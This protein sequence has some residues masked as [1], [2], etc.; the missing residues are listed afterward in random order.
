LSSW[1]V[2]GGPSRKLEERAVERVRVGQL[3]QRPERARQLLGARLVEHAVDVVV[4]VVDEQEAAAIDPRAQV[5]PLRLRERTGRCPVMYPNGWRSSVSDPSGTT[6]PLG[7][8]A[9]RGVAR[10]RVDQVRRHERAP[11]PQSP[12]SY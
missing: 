4:V 10:Q 5:A 11:S 1:L 9:Q 6:T 3:D 7:A 2:V 12:D 8:T